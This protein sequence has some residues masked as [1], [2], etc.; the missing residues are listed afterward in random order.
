LKPG[1]R[2]E[3]AEAS[4]GARGASAMSS[5]SSRV[6]RPSE[7][8]LD[9]DLAHGLGFADLAYISGCVKP[10]RRPRCGRAAVADMSMTTSL[11]ERCAEVDRELATRTTAS[12]SSPLTWKIG[13]WSI[14][15]TSVQYGVSARRRRVVKPIWLLT[16]TWIVPPVR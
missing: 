10:A 16:T 3:R 14:F 6:T 8:L 12:G 4:R 1:A 2:R 7:Q 15:A 5:A 13:A 11:L 9:V